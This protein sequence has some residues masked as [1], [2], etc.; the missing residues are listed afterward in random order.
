[1]TA[2]PKR[3]IVFRP[4]WSA[5][6]RGYTSHARFGKDGR[7]TQIRHG[8]LSRI[9]SVD[10]LRLLFELANLCK[11]KG[12]V[13]ISNRDLMTLIGAENRMALWRARDTLLDL[14]V[15]EAEPADGKHERFTYRVRPFVEI[16]PDNNAALPSVELM[17]TFAV[18][19]THLTITHDDTTRTRNRNRRRV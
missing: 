2:T 6:P 3:S 11:Y 16:T 18:P 19:I 17:E 8:V 14:G 10:A 9:K 13:T 4:G 1:V 7:L 5:A 15:I 12:T